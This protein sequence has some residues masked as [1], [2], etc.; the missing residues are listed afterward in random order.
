MNKETFCRH[1]EK[2]TGL[3]RPSKGGDKQAW[4]DAQKAHLLVNCPECLARRKTLNKM[5]ERKAKEQVYI[6][7]GLVKVKGPVSG[8]T[9]WE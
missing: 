1:L 4:W 8:K 6:D 9:Y 7:C 2:S 3:K 5:R